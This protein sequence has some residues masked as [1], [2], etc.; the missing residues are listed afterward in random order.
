MSYP[1]N[2]GDPVQVP[3][4]WEHEG[5]AAQVVGY[6]AGPGGTR[7]I[8][9]DIPLDDGPVRVSGPAEHV[10]RD[11]IYTWR[12]QPLVRE[13]ADVT[14]QTDAGGVAFCRPA[15]MRFSTARATTS[16]I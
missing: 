14:L 8:E 12:G 10:E 2:P 7:W 9:L 15:P 5:M 3:R 1:R 13:G 11:L 6:V 4:T 16:P